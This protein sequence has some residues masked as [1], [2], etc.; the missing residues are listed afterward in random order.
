MPN[1]SFKADGYASSVSR[2]NTVRS[3]L[4]ALRRRK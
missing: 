2:R 4:A 3:N 1:Y